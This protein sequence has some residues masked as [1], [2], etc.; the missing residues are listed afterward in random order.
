MEP[1][2]EKEKKCYET[3][4]KL[5][6]RY[7]LFLSLNYCYDCNIKLNKENRQLNF[8]LFRKIPVSIY[9]VRVCDECA[10]KEK[11]KDKYLARIKE[12]CYTTKKFKFS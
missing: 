4:C 3:L 5:S 12:N 11:I 7:V 8:L 1:L 9:T 2:T 10:I 6:S